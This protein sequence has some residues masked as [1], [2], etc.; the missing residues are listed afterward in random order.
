MCRYFLFIVLA[1][2]VLK[3]NTANLQTIPGGVFS[4]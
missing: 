4:Q 3:F 1:A 2:D